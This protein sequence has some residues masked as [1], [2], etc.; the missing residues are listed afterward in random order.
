[1]DDFQ[2]QSPALSA[3]V[4]VQHGKH[5]HHRSVRVDADSFQ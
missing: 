1:M 3:T 2:N 4:L 5:H